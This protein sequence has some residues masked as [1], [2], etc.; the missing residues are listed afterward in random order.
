[1]VHR[2]KGPHLLTI[3]V[4]A[5]GPF[6]SFRADRVCGQWPLRGDFARPECDLHMVKEG[7][8]RKPAV[9]QICLFFRVCREPGDNERQRIVTR[10]HRNSRYFN[11]VKKVTIA[12]G[13][14]NLSASAADRSTTRLESAVP[15]EGA[16][17]DAEAANFDQSLDLRDTANRHSAVL[18]L[19]P[20]AVVADQHRLWQNG[21]CGRRRSAPAPGA[22]CPRPTGPGS[23]RRARRP[24]PPRHECS[25][26]SR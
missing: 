9:C 3:Q 7:L 25:E 20:H 8:Q 17:A 21:R 10:R 4:G 14:G 11:T 19:E 22:I 6:S 24:A 23:G 1:M 2:T 16:A 13:G 18:G 15:G 5:Q 26:R 12:D